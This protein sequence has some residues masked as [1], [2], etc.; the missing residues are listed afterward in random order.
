MFDSFLRSLLHLVEPLGLVWMGLVVLAGLL[1][2]RRQW[3]PFTLAAVLALLITVIGGTGL[4]AW[5]LWRLEAPWAGLK[6]TDAPACDAI[7]VLGGGAEP[8]LHELGGVRLTKAGDRIMTGLELMRLG[9][10]PM[11]VLGGGFVKDDGVVKVESDLIKARIASWNL[12]AGWE[13]I[14]LGAAV[15]THDEALRLVP[16]ARQR[17]WRRI[18]LVTSANHMRRALP[19]YRAAG[20]DP[21]PAP[22]NFLVAGSVTRVGLDLGIPGCAGFER[23]GIWMHE[24]AGWEVY[25]RRGWLDIPQQGAGAK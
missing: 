15:D 9:R 22:C 12:P 23:M 11:L 13:L 17:G 14:S 3:V 7:V 10:A 20:F 1:W 18:L 25:R 2:R 21:V 24:I 19:V 4:S 8:S 16:T 6:I 5:M